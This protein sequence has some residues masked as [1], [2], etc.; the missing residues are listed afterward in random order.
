MTESLAFKSSEIHSSS[1]SE[2]INLNIAKP[3][4]LKCFNCFGNDNKTEYCQHCGGT[5][6]VT[7]SHP[8]ALLFNDILCQKL[9][10]NIANEPI[11]MDFDEV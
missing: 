6:Y 11:W 1:S 4:K 2:S 3:N 5:A 10:A 7:D 9:D 8:L